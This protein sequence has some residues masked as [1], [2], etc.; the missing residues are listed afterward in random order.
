MN[1]FIIVCILLCASSACSCAQ[2]LDQMSEWNATVKAEGL[3]QIAPLIAQGNP[4]PW[5]KL[6]SNTSNSLSIGTTYKPSE[7][8]AAL[9]EKIQVYEK[10]TPRTAANTEKAVAVYGSL[11]R[12]LQNSGGYINMC[13]ADT[14][15]RLALAR[16][17]KLL[18]NDPSSVAKVKAGL[19]TLSSVGFSAQNFV[20]IIND[21]PSQKVDPKV[22]LMPMIEI[23]AKKQIFAA[24]G[25][26]EDEVILKF[27]SNQAG[28]SNLIEKPDL[29]VLLERIGQ[30]EVVAQVVLAPLI[31]FIEQGGQCRDIRLDD[32]RPFKA[33]M[34]GREKLYKS[35][36]M[37]IQKTDVGRIFEVMRM[38]NDDDSANIFTKLA[39]Q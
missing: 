31:D 15:N 10:S 22:T 38:L 18:I 39:L 34:R 26:N 35:E 17:A 36:L 20:T 4:S 14:V 27:A 1:A 28:T 12:D 13:L 23:D 16:L 6:K 2:S 37:G 19:G 9:L 7:L 8:G 24:L 30:T 5:P 21:E 29:G 3:T 33:V 25:A 32:V 11:S